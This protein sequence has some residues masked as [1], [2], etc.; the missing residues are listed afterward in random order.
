MVNIADSYVRSQNLAQALNNPT[1]PNE[2]RDAIFKNLKEN[3]KERQRLSSLLNHNIN[4]PDY[5][6]KLESFKEQLKEKRK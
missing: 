6:T 4:Y 5:Q 3:D 2:E 1:L